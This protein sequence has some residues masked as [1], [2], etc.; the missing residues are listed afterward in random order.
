[1][2]SIPNS[3]SMQE[4]QSKSID[5]VRFPLILGVIFIHT[6]GTELL[7]EGPLSGSGAVQSIYEF[8]RELLSEGIGRV[9]VP[10]FFMI[11]G[12]LFFLNTD[13]NKATYLRKLRS[14]SKSLLIPYL[15]WNIAFLIF[16]YVASH[17]PV[18]QQFFKGA[19]YSL[20]F[21]LS[22]LWGKHN[23]EEVNPMTYPIAYQ[24]WFIRDLMVVVLLTPLIHL[25][26]QKLKQW[27]VCLLGVLWFF[28]WWPVALD[29]H[30]LSMTALFF[31]YAGAYCSINRFNVA[32]LT[33]Q[34]P[35]AIVY[36]Y[37]ILVV[38]DALTKGMAFN[39]YLHS[40][41]ILLGILFF[42]RIACDHTIN[43]GGGKTSETQSIIL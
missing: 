21:V 35:K 19:D 6:Y 30:G 5:L 25:L 2:T 29:C 3:M 37:P 8:T 7:S 26:I 17:L 1:M 11:S 13:F 9:A 36:A 43:R 40:V 22:S 16:Y 32:S 42:Y 4:V 10:L 15:F 31:F 23:P 14:R 34:V 38:M 28:G 33:R 41:G 20:E 39:P 24:F 12:F 27:G 18:L